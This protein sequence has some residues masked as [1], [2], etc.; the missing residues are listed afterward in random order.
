MD[1]HDA[2]RADG[3]A[4]SLQL[5]FAEL[6]ELEGLVDLTSCRLPHHEVAERLWARRHVHRV[7]ESA[8]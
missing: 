6:L 3:L 2:E 4:P 8:L 5:Q 1:A 7:T